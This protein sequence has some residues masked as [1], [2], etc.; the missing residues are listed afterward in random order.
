VT[1]RATA[2]AARA[3]A[4]TVMGEHDKGDDDGKGDNVGDGDGDKAGGQQRGQ[5]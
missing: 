2:M 1:K 3:M 4:M 5:G